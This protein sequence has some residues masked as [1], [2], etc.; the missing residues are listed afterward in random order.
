MEKHGKG[1]VSDP[2]RSSENQPYSWY[3]AGHLGN[4]HTVPIPQRLVAQ[5]WKSLKTSQKPKKQEQSSSHS[6]H[7]IYG[8]LEGAVGTQGLWNRQELLGAPGQSPWQS[9]WPVSGGPAT[10]NSALAGRVA[11]WLGAR[12]WNWA[13]LDSNPAPAPCDFRYVIVL[14][15]APFPPLLHKSNTFLGGMLFFKRLAPCWVHHALP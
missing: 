13:D 11:G 5:C 10:V 14:S 15:E 3:C 8:A 9:P 7:G 1:E 12:A 2:Q 6:G 4:G